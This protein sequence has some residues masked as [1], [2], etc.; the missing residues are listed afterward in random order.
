MHFNFIKQGLGLLCGLVFCCASATLHANIQS[1]SALTREALLEQA[2]KGG[3]IQE[4]RTLISEGVDI[5]QPSSS[6]VSPLHMAVINNQDEIAE[7]LVKSGANVNVP[8]AS[9]GASPLHLSALYGRTQIANFLI[10][11]GANVNANM[12]FNISPLLVAA[13]F[14]HPELIE[15]LL[16]NKA[17][18]QH[19]DQEGFTALHFAAQNGDDI[20]AKILLQHG[21][22]PQARDKTRNATPLMVATEQN[23]TNVM[24]LL[25]E[26]EKKE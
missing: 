17:N 23:H 25:E 13:Q 20:T 5:H 4:V 3:Q 24:Q 26:Y 10:R 8:D 11:N 15:L 21:A 12:K 16:Q 18:L 22:N 19:A 14:N 6:G 9:T 7:L 1:E 2:I